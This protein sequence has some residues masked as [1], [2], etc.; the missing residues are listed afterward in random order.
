MVA[1]VH[2]AD[3]KRI[4]DMDDCLLISAAPYVLKKIHNRWFLK[5]E[6]FCIK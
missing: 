2:S 5:V 4:L 6:Q 3:D 1:A